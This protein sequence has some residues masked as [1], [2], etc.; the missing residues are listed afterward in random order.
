MKVY[1]VSVYLTG[2]A[3]SVFLLSSLVAGFHNIEPIEEYLKLSYGLY[4]ELI[5]W[6]LTAVVFL[7]F[8]KKLEL[9]LVSYFDF[10]VIEVKI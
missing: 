4:A 5:L 9:Y 8:K 10:L 2:M 3:I 7:I 1:L 6:F